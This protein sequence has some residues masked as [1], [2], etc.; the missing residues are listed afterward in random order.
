VPDDLAVHLEDGLGFGHRNGV[1]VPVA[2]AH[3]KEV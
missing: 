3:E 1:D 2:K